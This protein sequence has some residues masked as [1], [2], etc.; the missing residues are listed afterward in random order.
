MGL[1]TITIPMETYKCLREHLE[2]ANEIFKS[3]GMVGGLASE[4][5]TPKPEPKRTNRQKIDAYKQ[6]IESGQR[7]KK[8]EY[9][10]KTKS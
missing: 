10:K 8:P 6:L 2:K 5:Q 4:R 1:E 7:V 9:L 3:L